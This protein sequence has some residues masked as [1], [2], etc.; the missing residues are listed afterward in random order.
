M[1]VQSELYH[2]HGTVDIGSYS[3]VASYINA[4]T[5]ENYYITAQNF[6][7]RTFCWIAAQKHFGRKT[8]DALH[9]ISARIK[10]IGG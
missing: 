4:R 5:I 7:G 6:D 9:S 1:E 2:L 8:L 3:Y 10:S